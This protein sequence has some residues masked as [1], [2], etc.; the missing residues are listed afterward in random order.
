LSSPKWKI[1]NLSGNES[2]R[3]AAQIILKERVK[4]VSVNIKLYLKE[5]NPI[6]LHNV[7][8]SIR[9]LRYNI[10]LFYPFFD[11]NKFNKFYDSLVD[12]Q[13]ATGDVRDI[14]IT[15]NNISLIKD[16]EL[17]EIQND[18]ISK[19]EEKQTVLLDKLRSMLHSFMV[20]NEMKSFIKLIR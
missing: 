3:K 16:L 20:S 9:R 17:N 18:L 14:Y 12:L 2:F 15:I 7:R 13:D 4:K 1:K 8:I 11:N 5:E 6:K 10:E 19:M